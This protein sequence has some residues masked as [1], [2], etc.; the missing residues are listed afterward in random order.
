MSDCVYICVSV[1]FVCLCVPPSLCAWYVS[2]GVFFFYLYIHV[3]CLCVMCPG[4][5]TT[6]H[7][8]GGEGWKFCVYPCVSVYLVCAVC[9]PGLTCVCSV[10]I[11]ESVYVCVS[12]IHI[13]PWPPLYVFQF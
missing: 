11:P 9:G 12:I 6:V 2:K 1:N 10:A 5:P 7:L 8:V 3:L 13:W 4:V